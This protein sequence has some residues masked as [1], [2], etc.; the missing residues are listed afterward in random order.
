[1]YRDVR[2][3]DLSADLMKALLER[4][5]LAPELVEDIHWG[6]VKQ[7]D[8][9]GFDIARMAALIAGL[10]LETGGS[11]VNRL[12]APAF[13]R[14]T[15]PRASRRVRDVGAGVRRP[16]FQEAGFIPATRFPSPGDAAMGVTVENLR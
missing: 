9:Q 16:T 8:E 1:M 14:S 7:Q 5:K 12:C 2:A 10:P 3:D 13:G 11:T 15:P 6:C 4:T